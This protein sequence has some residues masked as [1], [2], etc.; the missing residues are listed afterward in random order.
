MFDDGYAKVGGILTLPNES[1]RVP[2]WKLLFVQGC[3]KTFTI[4]SST[5]KDEP[6]NIN[7]C[8]SVYELEKERR[9]KASV[10]EW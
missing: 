6:L 7:V 9:E 10:H 2:L 1:I 4:Q 8:M 3:L 5:K